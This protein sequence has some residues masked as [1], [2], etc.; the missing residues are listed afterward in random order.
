MIALAGKTAVVT[1]AASG[2]GLGIARALGDAGMSVVLAD[3]QRDA[4]EQA[5]RELKDAG[6]H[7]SALVVDVSDPESVA[8]AA[9]AVERLCGGPHILVNNAGVAFH[10][11]AL[12]DV[13]HENWQWVLGVNLSG[14]INGVRCFLPMMKRRREG[15]VVNTASGS[16]FFI[17]PDRHQG[18]YA[19]SKFAVVAFSEALEQELRGSGIGVSVLCPGA[20]NTS[21]HESGQ[22]RPAQFGGPVERPDESFL[23]DLTAKGLSPE[24]VGQSVVQAIVEN[25]FYI[26][27]HPSMRGPIEARHA[28]ILAALDRVQ[29]SQQT[30]RT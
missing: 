30:G 13:T 29:A 15:H 20:V 2:I 21:L 26:F 16:G 22:R 5:A 6:I 1:G 4:V 18:P 28:R 23:K 3:I 12:Q 27:T 17:R 9:D 24:A 7:A 25:H 8:R 10:G 14:A 19:V 11:T